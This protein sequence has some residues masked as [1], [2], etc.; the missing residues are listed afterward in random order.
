ME[1][2]S[3]YYLAMNVEVD[4]EKY[5]LDLSIYFFLSKYSTYTTNGKC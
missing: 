3:N 4:G 1:F 2:Y 5:I